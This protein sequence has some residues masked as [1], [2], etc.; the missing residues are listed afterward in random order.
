MCE[1]VCVFVAARWDCLSLVSNAVLL[2]IS[3]AGNQARRFVLIGFIR[4]T[5]RLIVFRSLLLCADGSGTPYCTDAG[6]HC[7]DK[8]EVV[9][10]EY[11]LLDC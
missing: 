11:V 5:R 10:V 1:H 4:C 9:A 6:A 8:T 2:I 7:N 3:G